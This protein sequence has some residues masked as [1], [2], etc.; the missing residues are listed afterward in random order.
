MLP[1]LASIVSQLKSYYGR[2][3][4]SSSLPDPIDELVTTMLSQNTSDTNTE[5]AFA[6][7]KS[8]F[9]DWQAVIDAETDEVEEAI[10]PGGL[11]KQKA[12]RIQQVLSLIREERGEFDLGFLSSMSNNSAIEWLTRLPG[13]GRKTAACVLLFSLDMPVMPVDT[14]VHRVALRLG[15]IPAGTSADDAH[16]LLGAGMTPQETYDAHML[17]IRHGRHTCKARNPRCAECV[18]NP[19]CPSALEP[20]TIGTQ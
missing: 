13:V 12:P 2:P 10:R 1:D 15:L 5:R 9:Q 18:L 11:A 7:L 19:A 4:R 14:H 3:S 17:L 8:T 16:D 6:R 20:M